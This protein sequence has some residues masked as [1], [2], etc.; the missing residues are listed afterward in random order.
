MCIEK[1]RLRLLGVH[2]FIHWLLLLLSFHFTHIYRFVL[3]LIRFHMDIFFA[4]LKCFSN[5]FHFLSCFGA[6]GFLQIFFYII[7]CLLSFFLIKEPFAHFVLFSFQVYGY[8]II[9]DVYKN[10]WNKRQRSA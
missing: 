7:F 5:T 1:V 8:T 9:S 4:H 2:L 10:N 3:T 6:F